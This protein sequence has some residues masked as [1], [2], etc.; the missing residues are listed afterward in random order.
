M[1]RIWKAVCVVGGFGLAVGLGP[2]C[3]HNEASQQGPIT[4]SQA[5]SQKELQAAADAQQKALEQQKKTDEAQAKADKLKADLA[6]AQSQAQIER[7]QAQATQQKALNAN[8]ENSK[9]AEVSQQQALMSQ[10][11]E[12]KELKQAT[13]STEGVISKVRPRELDIVR[14]SDSAPLAMEVNANTVIKLNGRTVALA[15]IP[16]GTSVHVQFRMGTVLPIATRVEAGVLGLN[17]NQAMGTG[18]SGH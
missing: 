17:G 8:R 4:S 7:D 16:E 13:S 14:N 9:K 1:K 11:D 18:G 15:D 10:K 12:S 3:S 2:A 6:A 5:Q